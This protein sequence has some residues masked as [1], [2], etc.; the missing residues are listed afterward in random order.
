MKWILILATFISAN[1]FA[2]F[3]C[4]VSY[5]LETVLAGEAELKNSKIQLGEFQQFRFYLSKKNDGKV[6]LESYNMEDPSRSYAA[7]FVKEIGDTVELSIWNNFHIMTA[8][9]TLAN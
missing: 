5:N 8:K 3:H 7:S 6:E 1:A 9:C 2:N 4:E